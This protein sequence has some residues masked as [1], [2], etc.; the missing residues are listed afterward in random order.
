MKCDAQTREEWSSLE[1]LFSFARMDARNLITCFHEE[2]KR[3]LAGESSSLKMLPCFVNRPTG[4]E[5]GSFLALDLGGTNLRV[6]AVELDSRGGANISAVDRFIIP[7][8][9]MH[10]R[11]EEL[12][13]F[14]ADGVFLF[15]E[16][17]GYNLHQ[18]HDLAFT[19]SFPVEQSAL[20][21]GILLNWTKGF[22][23]SG[24]EGKDVVTLLAEALIRKNIKNVSVTALANDT[25]GTLMTKSY[26]DASCDMSVILGTGT[27]ACYSENTRR[28][29]KYTG[30]GDDREMIVNLE[31]GNFDRIEMNSYDRALDHATRNIGR[32]RLEKMVSGMYL[33]E[34]ARLIILDMIDRGCL[35]KKK[36]RQIFD[37]GY[38]ITTEHLSRAAG[39][40]DIFAQ[41]GLENVTDYDREA[42]VRIS[43]IVSKRAARIAGTAIA[44]VITWM[45][46]GLE[47]HHTVAVDGSLFEKYPG[48]S[49]NMLNILQE[50]FGDSA[51]KIALST[52]ADGS[53]IGAAIIAAV[54]SG[55]RRQ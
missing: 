28:I 5:E 20:N 4:L 38:A 36:D 47:R 13:D 39:G 51:G 14:L 26:T 3:G 35:L 27:N 37:R 30:S 46:A 29:A 15:L 18:H 41:F 21:S 48:F 31:W 7:A 17:H 22:T 8:S 52:A 55:R 45:D 44:S 50:L 34:L 43:H 25:I 10:G 40:E 54:A 1:S 42:A 9:V 16:K 2:M 23:A 6:L 11:G 53:G 49:T 19:F 12:F 33:G 32:Q 24:V